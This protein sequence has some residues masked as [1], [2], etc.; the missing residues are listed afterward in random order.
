MNGII[1]TLIGIGI[2]DYGIINSITNDIIELKVERIQED[3]LN[4]QKI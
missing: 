2:M 1:G 3:K 4:L